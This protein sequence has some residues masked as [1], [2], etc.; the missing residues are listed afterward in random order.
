MSL[1]QV[2][3]INGNAI[4]LSCY[5]LY[6]LGLYPSSPSFSVEREAVEGR[7]GAVTVRRD[8]E[9][10]ELMAEFRV[11][12]ADYVDSLFLRDELFQVFSD[13]FYIG[14]MRQ[15]GK[16]WFVELAEPWIPERINSKVNKIQLA[17]TAERGMSESIGTTLNP[18]TFE[19]E[20]WQVGQ[21]LISEDVKYIHNTSN[22]KIFNSGHEKIDPTIFPLKIIIKG[23]SSNLSIVNRTTGDTWQYFGSSTPNDRIELNGVRSLKNNVSIF[24]DT[25]RKLITIAPGWNNF[26]IN[27]ASGNFEISFD[28][29]FYYL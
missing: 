26:E 16:R 28:F 9:P 23:T 19:E 8:L 25:N 7:A 27:G 18:F 17:L 11:E 15:P 22:F 14:E 13:N 20:K 5:G 29:R 6:G 21:E 3:D 2:W 4:D 24:G 10:R 12:A 1:I